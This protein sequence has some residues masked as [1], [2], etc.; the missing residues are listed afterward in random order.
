MHLD[1]PPENFSPPLPARKKVESSVRRRKCRYLGNCNGAENLLL[2]NCY[3]SAV[4]MAKTFPPPPAA[5][6]LLPS[7]GSF[8]SQTECRKAP[9]RCLCILC[10]ILP[11][12]CSARSR[13]YQETSN[14]YI[15]RVNYYQSLTF[16]NVI[17]DV[18]RARK[19]K[20]KRK[21][22]REERKSFFPWTEGGRA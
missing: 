3:R 4:G 15:I 11:S 13:L 7:Y 20:P 5:S 17:I 16:M 1:F 6:P 21:E 10:G 22:I 18:E 8:Q 2:S 19:A 9:L 12:A 14:T